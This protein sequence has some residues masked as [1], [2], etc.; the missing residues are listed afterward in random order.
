MSGARKCKPAKPLGMINK[1]IPTKSCLAKASCAL[2]IAPSSHIVS[3]CSL[4]LL[5]SIYRI[6][7]CKRLARPMCRSGGCRWFKWL[8]FQD[9]QD[10]TRRRLPK[11][12]AHHAR[13]N[14]DGKEA[15]SDNIVDYKVDTFPTK[16]IHFGL[17]APH[18]TCGTALVRQ[19]GLSHYSLQY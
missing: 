13:A 6:K 2:A 19:C 17:A 9:W 5:A 8:A 16:N 1:E 14:L 3:S 15:L 10:G 18:C 11:Y 7:I 12:N 4:I